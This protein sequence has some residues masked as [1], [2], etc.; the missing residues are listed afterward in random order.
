MICAFKEPPSCIIYIYKEAR[1]RNKQLLSFWSCVWGVGVVF[2]NLSNCKAISMG[3]GTRRKLITIPFPFILIKFSRSVMSDSLRPHGWQHIR[4]PYPSPTP[5]VCSNS[6]PLTVMPS[7]LCCPLLLLPSIFPSIR[8]FSN[9]S[10]LHITWQSIG[11]SASI[12]VLPMNI[13]DWFPL[14]LTDLISL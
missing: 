2:L 4:H 3:F 14:G 13:Q 8:V 1:L 7:T 12:S 10:A 5:G 11:A 9:E 6:C